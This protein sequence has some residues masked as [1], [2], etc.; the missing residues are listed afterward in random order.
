M[1]K[2]NLYGTLGVSKVASEGEIK[3]AFYKLALRSHP[4]KNPGD[5][6]AAARFRE[7][8]RAY[9]VLMDA[10]KRKRYDRTGRVG[11]TPIEDHV[12]ISVDDVEAFVREYRNSDAETD[13]LRAYTTS[14]KGDVT[15]VL[16][17]IIGSEDGDER[18]YV[19]TIFQLFREKKLPNKFRKTFLATKDRIISLADLDQHD[20]EDLG[21]DDDDDSEDDELEDDDDGLFDDDDDD[22]DDR[23]N[24]DDDDDDEKKIDLED[25][26]EETAPQSDAPGDLI[27][28]FAAR[29]AQR[30]SGFDAFAKRWQA[31]SEE[32]A[33]L[34]KEKKKKKKDPPPQRKGRKRKLPAPK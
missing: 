14:R 1:V 33:K 6:E 20:G 25:V 10:T 26:E 4:D 21:D 28:M 13:D 19:E 7:Q 3:K 15:R 5:A 24:K 23:E 12:S 30:E 31:V 29:R 32:E 22:D 18:R 27:A 34:K 9:D 8:K 16:E 17:A 2:E 11:D